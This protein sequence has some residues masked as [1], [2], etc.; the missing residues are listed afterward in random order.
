MRPSLTKPELEALMTSDPLIMPPLSAAQTLP[1]SARG[2]SRWILEVYD[3][4]ILRISSTLIWRCP[5][6]RLLSLYRHYLSH[7][8]LEV[9]V[10]TGYLLDHGTFP[11][12]K[13]QLTLLDCNPQVLAHAKRRLQRYRP[14]VVVHDVMQSD[15][16]KLPRYRSIGFNY[17]WHALKG[18]D[19]ERIKMLKRLSAHLDYEGMLFG[20][21]VI[22]AHPDMSGIAQAVSRHWQRVGVFN[23]QH[24]DLETVKNALSDVFEDIHIWQVGYVVMFVATQPKRD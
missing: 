6:P 16:P 5:T 24:D 22:G 13:P 3:W 21:T 10:G 18:S 19:D 11:T 12:L 1:V 2:Y 9:G 20:S 7:R 4:L 15:W 14:S 23:N 17:V 8:H